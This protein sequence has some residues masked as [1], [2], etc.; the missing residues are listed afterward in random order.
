MMR[1]DDQ[2]RNNGTESIEVGAG[3]CLVITMGFAR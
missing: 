2:V 1:E 3:S